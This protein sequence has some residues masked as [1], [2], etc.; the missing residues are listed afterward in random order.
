MVVC[1]GRR[2]RCIEEAA[3]GEDVGTRFVAPHRPHEI[4]AKK[5]WIALGDASRGTVTVDDGAKEALVKHG[6]SL[7]SVGL[8]AVEGRFDCDDIV[9]V[10]DGTGHVFGRGRAAAGSDL[11]QL[12]VGH[13]RE[14]VAENCILA[15]LAERPVIHRDELVLFE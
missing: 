2:P 1:H 6:S 4:S 8:R 15:P 9:D 13:S 11:L 7:L 5:L 10:A 12:A 14:E 3:A